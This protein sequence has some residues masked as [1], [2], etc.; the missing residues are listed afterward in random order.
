MSI[1]LL[2]P[3]HLLGVTVNSTMKELKKSYYRLSLLCHPDKG[4][5]KDDMDIVHKAYLYV[6]DQIVN[7]ENSITYEEAEAQFEAFCKEQEAKPPRF[8][9][10]YEDTNDFVR[11]F[12]EQFEKVHKETHNP[13]TEG[14]GHLM[15]EREDTGIDY[16]GDEINSKTIS[17]LFNKELVIYKEPHYL[18]DNYGGNYNFGVKNISDFSHTVNNMAMTDYMVAFSPQRR[19]VH[20][21]KKY[22]SI[23]EIIAERENEMDQITS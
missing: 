10:I 2:N 5:N 12:R 3:Y 17:N 15:D 18:P 14:Y 21:R 23:E 6:K 13:F 9:K 8:S 11:D 16:N 19:V 1:N 7:N 20:N 22:E 4:G